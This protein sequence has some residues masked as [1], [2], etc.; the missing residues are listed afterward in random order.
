MTLKILIACG[1][2]GGHLFPGIAVAEALRARGHETLA[3]IS[4]KDIDA[5]ASKGYSHLNFKSLPAVG[6]PRKKL[7]PAM[8][9]F[10]FRYFATVKECKK[11]ARQFGAD[12]VIGMGGFTSLPPVAAGK[13]IGAKA[14]VHDSNAVPGKSNRR[15]ATYCNEVLLGFEEASK[16]FSGSKT[17]VVGTPVRPEMDALPDREAA[18]ANFQLDPSKKTVLIIGGSQ[19]AR[20]V[21]LA[22]VEALPALRDAGVQV[23]HFTGPKE[24]D[25]TKIRYDRVPGGAGSHFLAPFCS[26]MPA[27]YA[28]AHLV[29]ARSGAS[30]LAELSYLGLPSVL[31]PY[32]YAADNH[33]MRNAEVFSK[34]E[35]AVLAPEDT[36]VGGR[37]AEILISLF[38]DE[39]KLAKLSTNSRNLSHRDAAG[40]IAERIEKACV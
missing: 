18:A 9:K 6:M 37:L 21:N 4:E 28:A 38:E 39:A 26:D 7:S 31:V 25:A 3:L 10:V 11:I 12:A 23:L 40:A 30:T 29:V 19:G 14:F 8:L 22:V 32:P 34:K 1:G 24:Y 33:Q 2:T 27:A 16:F 15:T 17:A 36:L 35:A 5:L 13:K 20:G